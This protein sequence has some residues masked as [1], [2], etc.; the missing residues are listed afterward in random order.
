MCRLGGRV[1]FAVAGSDLSRPRLTGGTPL[2]SNVSF[3]CA[4][5]CSM[6]RNQ[7]PRPRMAGVVPLGAV[8]PGRTYR[9]GSITV[10][11]F[12]GAIGV[13]APQDY[14]GCLRRSAVT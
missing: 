9:V 12:N 10:R 11:K 7:L 4:I 1:A 5:A 2:A 13:L 14:P 8:Y 6:P 3:R